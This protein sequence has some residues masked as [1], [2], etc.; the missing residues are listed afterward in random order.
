MSD[1]VTQLRRPVPINQSA[2]SS[3]FSLLGSESY[4]SVIGVV[5]EGFSRVEKEMELKLIVGIYY[6]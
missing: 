6:M 3:F 1:I 2:S 4:F 5:S